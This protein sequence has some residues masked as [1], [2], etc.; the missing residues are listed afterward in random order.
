MV[1]VPRP[2]TSASS[3]FHSIASG[4]FGFMSLH[5]RPTTH[6]S[7]KP[8][9]K[10]STLQFLNG[11]LQR[12]F[13]FF[14]CCLHSTYASL[15][16]RVATAAHK[17]DFSASSVTRTNSM[18]VLRERLGC[19]STCFLRRWQKKLS[20]GLIYTAVQQLISLSKQSEWLAQSCGQ[21]LGHNHLLC[22]LN[23]Y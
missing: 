10:F 18:V 22:L 8:L 11:T 1:A 2:L 3:I 4:T 23:G 21:A 16:L 14:S 13:L 12:C 7:T 20:G 19:R 5:Y 6:L 15:A 17:V 9:E